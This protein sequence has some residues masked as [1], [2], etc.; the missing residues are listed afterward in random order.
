M[1]IYTPTGGRPETI[2]PFDGSLPLG[3]EKRVGWGAH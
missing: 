2:Y 1:R 3:S